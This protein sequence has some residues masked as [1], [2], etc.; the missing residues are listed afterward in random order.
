MSLTKNRDIP[1]TSTKKSDQF[2]E[3][4]F[5]LDSFEGSTIWLVYQIGSLFKK[6]LLPL[7]TSMVDLPVVLACSFLLWVRIY[8]CFLNGGTPK[9]PQND[10]F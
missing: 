5:I 4:V 7:R 3:Q 8:G 9:T 10:L 2:Q 6:P 1:R